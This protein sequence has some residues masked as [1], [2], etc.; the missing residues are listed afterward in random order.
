MKVLDVTRNDGCGAKLP[1]ISYKI[2][3]AAEILGVSQ[4]TVR[5]AIKRGLL[6]PCR[7]LRHPLIP[8]D[9]LVKLING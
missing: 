9:Q 4:A 5:R 7:V 1:R 2:K 8:S 3:E 6:R